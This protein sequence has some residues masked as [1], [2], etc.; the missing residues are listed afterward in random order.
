MKI[1]KFIKYGITILAI[2]AICTLHS[3]ISHART[4]TT[5]ILPTDVAAASKGNVLM[6]VEGSFADDVKKAV[7]RVNAIRKEACKNGYPDPRNPS[8]KLTMS[9][10]VPI[11][12][13]SELEFI[14]RIRAA[15]ASICFDHT[16]PTGASCFDITGPNSVTSYSEV[17]AWGG[18]TITSSVNLW[19][20][21]KN[22][23]V[24]QAEGVTGHYTSMINP[25][26]TYMGMAN[27][28][29]TGAGEFTNEDWILFDLED[30]AS[31]KINETPLSSA[32]NIIQTIE[33]PS[34][35]L[36]KAKIV[37]AS[38]KTVKKTL[39]NGSSV[40]CN[41]IRT[42]K[43][44]Q[45][46]HV[47]GTIS[48]NSSNPSAATVNQNGKV[49]AVGYGKAKITA[50]STVG[51]SASVTINVPVK[52]TASSITKIKPG[53]KKLTITCKKK[54]VDGYEVQC[55][56]KKNFKSG[57]KKKM[58]SGKNKTKIT[59]TRLASKKKYYVRIRSYKILNGK[60]YYSSWSKT[61]TAKTK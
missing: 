17:L 23:W 16:R 7:S 4:A 13:S 44:G 1:R 58:V 57:V 35:S 19:Y 41:L 48:W 26:T 11:K 6:G 2:C 40:G 43:G 22:I 12:W 59:V 34:S 54:K 39:N 27:F 31:V 30:G 24:K 14:A 42:Y 32:K 36:S 53:R 18:N 49:T 21:E 51:V 5:V 15:E 10:Y 3:T 38:G 45:N 47:L 20:T 25:D 60:K 37:T 29:G 61:K 55:S 56:K 9:D 50:V 46:L 52:V 28:D 8:R 33:V